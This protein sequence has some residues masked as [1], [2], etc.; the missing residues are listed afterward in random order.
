MKKNY[1]L[2]L[3]LS[4]IGLCWAQS[5]TPIALPSMFADH[6]VLQQ[7]TSASVWGWGN[8]SSMVKIVGSWAEKDT[9]SAKVDCFGRWKAAIPT[10]KSGGP[11]TLQV[12]DDVSKVVLKD[13]LLGEVWLC[14]GQSNM[15]W[16]PN[17][18]LTDKEHEV[19]DASCPDIRI[20]HV[21]KRASHSLQEDCDGQWDICTPEVMRKRS[22]IAYFFARH[23]RD[24]LQVP[25]GVMVAAWGGT[26]AE[27]WTPTEIVQSNPNFRLWQIKQTYPWWPMEAGVL[28]N[29]MIH[30][31]LPFTFAGTIWYQGETNRDNPHYYG[32]LMKSMIEAWRREAGRCFPFYQVQIAPFLYKSKDNGPALIR[33]AQE[34]VTRHTEETGLVVI[35][36]CVED[37]STIHPINKRPVGKRLA[38]LVLAL[39]SAAF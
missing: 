6:M 1:L 16:T 26:P 13:I 36:D 29:H 19:A 28:Y 9:I 7:N 2:L 35:S 15:E 20:F 11:Y 34:W 12:F 25:V 30:P 4:K 8:A 24:S 32:I 5:Y 23:L 3:F 39:N 33:E 37:I 31:L 10:T 22:A 21:P 18:G 17:N 14:S 38:D 27:S